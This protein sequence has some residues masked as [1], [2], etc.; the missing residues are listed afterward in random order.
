M[1][2]TSISLRIYRRWAVREEIPFVRA[3]RLIPLVMR[4]KLPGHYLGAL[5]TKVGIM[6]DKT[7]FVFHTDAVRRVYYSLMLCILLS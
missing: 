1:H 5:D 4:E 7:S 2:C 6:E 3:I